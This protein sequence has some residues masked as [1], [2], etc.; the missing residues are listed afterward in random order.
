M[1]SPLFL[2]NMYQQVD[3][4]SKRHAESIKDPGMQPQRVLISMTT[5]PVPDSLSAHC[6][7]AKLH[8]ESWKAVLRLEFNDADPSHMAPEAQK[9]YSFFTQDQAMAI[10]RFLKQHEHDTFHVVVHCEAGVSRSAAVAK[11]IALIYNLY[12]PDRYDVY[13]KHVF[14]TILK[15]Y[16]ES[17]HGY[18]LLQPEELPGPF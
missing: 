15:V 2:T 16:G 4:I 1:L 6:S 7:P 10:L 9:L 17:L 18:G 3:F 12:F 8:P 11:F 13:N 14:S 5:P